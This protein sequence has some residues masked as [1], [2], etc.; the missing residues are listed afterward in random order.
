MDVTMVPGRAGG[1]SAFR[2][3]MREP[4]SGAVVP[5]FSSVHEKLL[6][7]FI[8]G[9]DLEYFAHVHPE[10]AGRGMFELTHALPAGAFVVIAD[11]V[12]SG[13]SAQMIQRAVVTPGYKGP[14]F[15]TTP[16]LA[17]NDEVERTVEGVKVRLEATGL[18]AGREALLRLAFADAATGTPVADLEPFLG[19]PAH[20]LIVN[21]ELTESIHVHPEGP[22]AGP[23]ESARGP[24]I[25]FR[26]RMPAPGLYKLWVQFQRKGRVITVPFILAVEAA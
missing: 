16:S 21:A 26:P 10:P 1:V 19:A 5:A 15:P 18:K 12:P 6:H 17:R 2:I 7:F 13:G 25:S 3:R 24:V 4:E 9:R 14:L 22:P 8:I 11:F 23:G 20:M